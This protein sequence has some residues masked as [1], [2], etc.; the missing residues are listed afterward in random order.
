MKMKVVMHPRLVNVVLESFD[1]ISR[2]FT[3]VHC[4]QGALALINP[5]KLVALTDLSVKIPHPEVKVSKIFRTLVNKVSRVDQRE[6]TKLGGL[7]KEMLRPAGRIPPA[8][9]VHG[10]ITNECSIKQSGVLLQAMPKSGSC[11][12]DVVLYQLKIHIEV[13]QPPRSR[14][15]CIVEELKKEVLDGLN[16]GVKHRVRVC[17]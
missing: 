1:A 15:G 5:K 3:P 8:L 17:H 16:R 7:R 14:R 10:D 2:I 12:E 11:L 9:S 6:N 13:E 4:V